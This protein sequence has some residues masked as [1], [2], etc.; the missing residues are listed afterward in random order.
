ML[1]AVAAVLALLTTGTVLML[2]GD[3]NDPT[4]SDGRTTAT[5]SP[6]RPPRPPSTAGSS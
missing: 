4:R 5:S 1:G 3:G 2:R 6:P